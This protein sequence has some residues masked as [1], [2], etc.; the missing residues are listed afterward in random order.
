MRVI[1]PPAEILS[2]C[3]RELLLVEA[4]LGE[5]DDTF[6]AFFRQRFQLEQTGLA[7]PGYVCTPGGR[8]LELVFLG[9]SGLPFPS[10]V[11]IHALVP[12]LEPLDDAAAEADLADFMRWMFTALGAPWSLAA[13]RDTARLYHPPAG[14]SGGTDD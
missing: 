6:R 14:H 9:R 10:G 11:E 8:W 12:G 5:E 1:D 2:G 7:R 13:W 4:Q 3:R